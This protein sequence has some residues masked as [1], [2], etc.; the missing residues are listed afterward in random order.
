[1]TEYLKNLHFGQFLERIFFD[2]INL[3]FP[4]VERP[5]RRKYLRFFKVPGYVWTGH[6]YQICSSYYQKKAANLLADLI[7][8]NCPICHSWV[9]KLLHKDTQRCLISALHDAVCTRT[10]SYTAA[11]VAVYPE[12]W[13]VQGR[14]LLDLILNAHPVHQRRLSGADTAP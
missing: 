8:I 11:M 14:V 1:M 2:N 12:E 4:V 6:Y 5:N 9:G 3:S 13:R 7:L 10:D